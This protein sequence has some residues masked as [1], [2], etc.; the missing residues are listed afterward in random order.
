MAK[1]YGFLVKKHALSLAILKIVDFSNSLM[2]SDPYENYPD[3]NRLCLFLQMFLINII[4][5]S[6]IKNAQQ[7]REVFERISQVRE[8]KDLCKGIQLI[9]N[10]WIRK[11]LDLLPEAE[12]WA[13][14]REYSQNEPKSTVKQE[15][16]EK[17]ELVSDSLVST[18]GY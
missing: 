7:L 5:D 17:L 2:S 6:S 16:K 8:L 11:R 13:I 9:L 3:P 12:I 1:L 10:Y 15:L 14:V 4:M 18:G